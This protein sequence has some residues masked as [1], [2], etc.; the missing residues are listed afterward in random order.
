MTTKMVQIKKIEDI[1]R[2]YR[3]D[4]MHGEPEYRSMERKVAKLIKSLPKQER[5][6]YWREV[7]W[8]QENEWID[9]R[10]PGWIAYE[11]RPR[12]PYWW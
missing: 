6:A 1:M 4:H 3:D 10:V 8:E 5:E 2:A 12:T 7:E 11:N 9:E